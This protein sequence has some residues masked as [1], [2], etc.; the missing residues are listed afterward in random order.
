M[1]LHRVLLACLLV[2]AVLV[3]LALPAAQPR[4][5]FTGS[6]LHAHN[7]YP[8][9]G[10]WTDR[11]DRAL[12]TAPRPIAIEQDVAWFEDN[13]GRGRSVVTHNLPATGAEPTLEAHFFDRVRP[14]MDN[15]LRTPRPETWPLVVLHLD[16]KSNERAHHRAIWD[17]LGR[18]ERWLTTATRVAGDAVQPFSVGPLLVLTENGAGQS[19]VFHDDVPVGGRLRLFGTVPPAVLT[20][21]TDREV[22]FDRAV[23]APPEELIPAG[24]TNYRRWVN[25]SWLV[26]ERGGQARAGAW[27]A[28]DDARLRAIVGRAHALGLWVRFYTL[29]GHTPANGQGWTE[30]YNFGSPEAV[31]PRWRAAIATGVD[32]VATDQYEGFAA[33]LA[34]AR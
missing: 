29:N 34:A 18:H 9:N 10:R 14:L 13:G 21:S 1:R 19:T 12:S 15:A 16:F 25:F 7:C 20:T 28:A 11:L 33:A 22:Q 24:A 5:L 27:T 26:V 6:L 23:A 2:S 30:S 31:A 32:F 3:T 17:L 4:P 8:D